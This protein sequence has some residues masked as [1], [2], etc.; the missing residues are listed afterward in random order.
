VLLRCERSPSNL[1]GLTELCSSGRPRVGVHRR[2]R[3]RQGARRDSRHSRTG[4]TNGLDGACDLADG[5]ENTVNLVTASSG[6]Q[7]TS[8]IYDRIDQDQV[9]EES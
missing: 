6:L 2:W 3:L 5:R 8:V 1:G 7:N 4:E 9:E